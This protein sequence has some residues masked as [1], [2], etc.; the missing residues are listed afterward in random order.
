VK[1]LRFTGRRFIFALPQ[2][3]AVTIVTFFIIRLLP[4]DPAIALAGNYATPQSIANIRHDLG[5]DRPLVVQYGIY[6]DHLIHGNLGE[7][8]FS[9]LPVTKELSVRI[10][11]TLELI[12]YALLLI[13]VGG[14]GV[15]VLLGIGKGRRTRRAV[16]TYGYLAGSFPDFYLG[17]VLAFVFFYKLRVLPAP[18]GRLGKGVSAP[19]R[20]TGFYTV[21]AVLSGQW[22]TLG[23]SLEH[24]VLPVVTLALVYAAPV[25]KLSSAVSEEMA[26]SEFC[27]YARACGLPKRVIARYAVRNSLP[28]VVTLVGFTYGYLLGGA[29]LVETI[30][31]W[32]GVGQYVVTAVQNSDYFPVQGVVLVAAL[33]NLVV[34]FVVD[35]LHYA[36]D[37]RLE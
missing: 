7:S 22:A 15:G 37:P 35:V 4:G 28:P 31:S 27:R 25:L 24:L 29:V 8:W 17:L 33:F 34:Y 23:N 5:L 9:A 3:I 30:Y 32:G 13:V 14:V 26:N 36:I 1:L 2:V 20:V 19:P 10:P 21:D 11:A 16:R 6:V 18:F 12:T